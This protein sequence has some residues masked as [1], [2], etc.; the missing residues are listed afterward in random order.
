MKLWDF[1][2]PRAFLLSMP[3]DMAPPNLREQLISQS[4]I[5]T[6]IHTSKIHSVDYH[7]SDGKKPMEQQ[8]A[9]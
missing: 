7:S 1:I 9:Y 8:I 5:V 3:M 6:F 4:I 2:T